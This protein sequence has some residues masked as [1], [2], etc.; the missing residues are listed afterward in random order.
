MS[1]SNAEK[2]CVD[3]VEDVGPVGKS[4]GD[5][6]LVSADGRI[7][8]LPVPSKDPNDPL[9]FSFKAKLGI[10]VSCCWFSIM[11]LS[12]VGGLGSILTIFIDLYAKEGVDATRVGWLTTFP[13]LFIGIGNYFILPLGLAFG[14]RPVTLAAII[15]L[16]AATIGCALSQNYT[17][18]FALRIIQ[19]LA[20]GATESLLP[21]ILAEVTFVHQRGKIYGLYWSTQNIINSC[22][23]IASSYEAAALGWRWYY[24]IFVITVGVGGLITFFT[25]FETAYSRSIQ[26]VDGNVVTTDEYGV[27]RVLTREEAQTYITANARVEGDQNGQSEDSIPKKTYLE[28]LKPWSGVKNPPFKTMLDSWW[29]ML[30]CLT[31]PGII[32]A[33]LLSSAVLAAAIG[34]GLTY[35][36]VLQSYGWQA[37]N[38]GLINLG[39]VFGSFGG[40]LYGGIFGDWFVIKVAKRCGGAHTPEHRLLL[41]I[42]PGVITVFTLLLYGFTAG[43]G[44]TWGGPYMAWAIFEVAFVAVL[45]IST[46]FAAEAWD[47]NAGPALVIV[48]GTKNLVSFGIAYALIP[49]VTKYSYAAGMGM[50]A[51]VSAFIFLLGIPV[52]YL[53]PV[54]RRYMEKKVKPS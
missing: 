39:G 6:V 33:T 45:I 7:Q 13:S 54:W 50:L 14:R 19:G 18:H 49:M 51:G 15:V 30:L 16:L 29:R 3:M 23:N 46:T 5:D 43:G 20:T 27:T 38:V 21:L 24:W 37:K 10:I 2:G 47:H 48:V 31:S 17:Q 26:I 42:G 44:S 52:Y 36:N 28:L 35:D 4:P 32:Y 53:N 40:L 8:L 9:N 11:S 22:F 1:L 34:M 25:C 12:V 41:L